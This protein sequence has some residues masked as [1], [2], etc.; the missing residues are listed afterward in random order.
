MITFAENLLFDLISFQHNLATF[1]LALFLFELLFGFRDSFLCNIA[2]LFKDFCKYF[3]F[4]IEI[5]S[6][7]SA[8]FFIPKSIPT[9]LFVLSNFSASTSATTI[10]IYNIFH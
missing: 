8:K 5:S 7:V 4:S 1:I 2:S 10:K 3:G 9:F 6:L